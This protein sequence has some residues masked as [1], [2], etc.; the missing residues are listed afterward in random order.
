MNKSW[1]KRC[2][3]IMMIMIIVW[4]ECDRA[5]AILRDVILIWQP[6]LNQTKQFGPNKEEQQQHQ[7]SP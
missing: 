2:Q 1:T 4:R 6:G 7:A 5:I 3:Q